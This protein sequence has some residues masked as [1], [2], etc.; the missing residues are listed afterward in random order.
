M[1][2]RKSANINIM[3]IKIKEAIE[4]LKR[5]IVKSQKIEKF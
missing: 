5:K 2:M 4:S 1:T 3:S